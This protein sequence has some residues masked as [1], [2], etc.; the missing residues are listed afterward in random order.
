MYYDFHGKQS[1]SSLN[2]MVSFS[3]SKLKG[4]NRMHI[5]PVQSLE[6]EMN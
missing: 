6:A 2:F 3:L 5:K 1:Y 4:I